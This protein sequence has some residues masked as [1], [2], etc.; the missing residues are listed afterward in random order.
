LSYAAA[1]WIIVKSGGD[2]ESAGQSRRA[3]IGSRRA[4]EK[5]KERIERNHISRMKEIRR[6]ADRVAIEDQARKN[7]ATTM[8]ASMPLILELVSPSEMEEIERDFEDA[9]SPVRDI[10][11]GLDADDTLAV[12]SDEYHIIAS[13]ERPETE[14]DCSIPAEECA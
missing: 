1:F 5:V 4:S 14:R 8:N 12:N 9:P 6:A 3:T 13:D 7:G 11:M 2:N 10:E